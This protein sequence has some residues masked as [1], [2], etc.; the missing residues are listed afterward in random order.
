MND[1]REGVTL[2]KEMRL[3]QAVL[4]ATPAEPLE[5]RPTIEKLLGEMKA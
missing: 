5:A 2:E 4:V 1:V 3:A